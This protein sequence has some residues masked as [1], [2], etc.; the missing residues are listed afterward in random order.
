M[1]AYLNSS[2]ATYQKNFVKMIELLM[3]ANPII[4]E[5]RIL[6]ADG[7]TMG[8]KESCVRPVETILSG[9]AASIM[10]AQSL[11]RYPDENLVVV[12]IGG[13]TTDIAV[14][15]GGD[16]L[17]QRNGAV[18]DG[19]RTLVPA[20]LTDSIGLGGDSEIQ[21]EADKVK[22]GPKRAGRAVALGGGKITPTDAAVALG[23]VE[24]G[25]Q[26]KSIAVLTQ[27]AH[28]YFNS[29]QELAETILEGFA[30]KLSEAIN[31]VYHDLENVPVYTVSEILAPPD[32]FPKRIVGLGT[33][34]KVFIP[35]GAAKLDLPY[36]I[37]PY[38]A[39]SNG[40]GAA[41]ARPTV[42]IT[43][44]V[45]TEQELMI[46][47]ELGYQEHLRRAM[48]FDQKRARE[49]V[50]ERLSKHAAEIGLG[51][52]DEIQIVEEEEFNLVRGFRTVGRIFNIKAQIRPGVDRVV[53]DNNANS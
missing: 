13:T 40:I 29:W 14:I 38:H 39:G 11:A 50:V 36:E 42:A 3:E 34:A 37:L 47:P 9:P 2:V 12:D 33:P 16:A 31:Q 1:S 32:I 28:E 17:S 35:L 22:I 51:N 52:Y 20:L 43:L 46:I 23:L 44:H 4:A 5:V 19:K 26:S 10:A 41:V 15:V 25:D 49:V 27:I 7:G 30:T 53:G 48:L 21:V 8:L 18:I 24:L 45:D 6:K